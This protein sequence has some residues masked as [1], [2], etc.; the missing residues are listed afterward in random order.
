MPITPIPPSDADLATL[1]CV[2]IYKPTVLTDGWDHVDAGMDDGVFWALKKLPGFDVVVLRGS[3]IR[4]DWVRDFR[5]EAQLTP[6][7]H[8][9]SGFLAGMVQM[10]HELKLRIN[11]PTIVTGHSL[12]AARAAVLTGLMAQAGESP[13]SRVVFGEPKPGLADL[14]E[15][16]KHVVG[17]SYRNGDALHHDLVTD[18]P[19]SFPPLQYVHPTPVIPVCCRPDADEFEADGPFAWHHGQLYE[20]ALHVFEQEKAA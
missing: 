2:D 17:R 20:T 7:G 4:L 18:V 9:H 1:A 6:I 12:G 8:V 3:V 16:I 10:W 13:I 15:F 5:A 19:F 11:Q 14:A